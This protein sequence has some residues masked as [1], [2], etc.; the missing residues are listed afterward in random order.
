VGA[1][2]AITGA[3]LW[4]TAPDGPEVTIAPVVGPSTVGVTIGSRL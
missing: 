1:A 3:V 4:W 2:V